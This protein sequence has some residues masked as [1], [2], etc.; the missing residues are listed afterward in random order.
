MNNIVPILLIIVVAI[1]VLHLFRKHFKAIVLPNVFLVSGAVKSGKT[2]L[3]VHLAI[4][5][6]KKNLRQYYIAKV[7]ATLVGLGSEYQYPPMLYSNIP[8]AKVKYN[9]LT[10]DIIMQKYRIPNKSV[11]LIDEASLLAD[12]MLFKDQVV[13]NALMR[14]VKL[15]AHYTHGGTLIIDTQSVADNHFSIRRCIG[16]YVYIYSRLKLPFISILSVRE[17]AYSDDK[18]IVSVSTSDIALEMRKVIIFNSTYKKYDCCC[19]SVF[20]DHLSYY[21][22]YDA[23]KRGFRDDLKCHTIV[24][25]QDFAKEMNKELRKYEEEQERLEI[26]EENLEYNPISKYV[27][28]EETGEVI[29]EEGGID[30]EETK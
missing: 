1:L 27:I 7:F 20:T 16:S 26:E 8:L 6:Y 14:F 5:Q 29:D 24:T 4:K 9:P 19:Y 3:S 12:S 13:N 30:E 10:I 18:S 25:F 21:V 17:M 23:E 28:D 11:V 15:F 2:L 22:D